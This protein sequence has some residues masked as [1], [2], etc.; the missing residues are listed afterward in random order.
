M[1]TL[2]SLIISIKAK[3]HPVGFFPTFAMKFL[4]NLSV[5]GHEHIYIRFIAWD[6]NVSFRI[7]GKF[8]VYN[9]QSKLIVLFLSFFDNSL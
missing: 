7:T 9:I 1:V 6:K 4:H 2:R 5:S 8:N 3:T